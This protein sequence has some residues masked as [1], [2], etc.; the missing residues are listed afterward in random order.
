[1]LLVVERIPAVTVTASPAKTEETDTVSVRYPPVKLEASGDRVPVI[2]ESTAPELNPATIFPHPSRALALSRK[3][4]P[5][6]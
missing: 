5:E 2:S 1:M 6:A 3:G 4:N